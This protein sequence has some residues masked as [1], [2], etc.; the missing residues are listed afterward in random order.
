MKEINNI[1]TS[2]INEINKLIDRKVESMMIKYN[3]NDEK[4]IKNIKN[5]TND[6][7]NNSKKDIYKIKNFASEEYNLLKKY[8]K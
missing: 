8:I 6:L 3:L 2:L 5:K 1:I 4:I 7:I